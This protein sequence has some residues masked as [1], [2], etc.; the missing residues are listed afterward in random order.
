MKEAIKLQASEGVEVT[1]IT[2]ELEDARI[3]GK[4]PLDDALEGGGERTLQ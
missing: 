1:M 4:V 2:A 3:G